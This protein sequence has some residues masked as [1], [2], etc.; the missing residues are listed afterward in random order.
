MVTIQ[1]KLLVGKRRIKWKKEVKDKKLATTTI[2]CGFC[3]GFL[4]A[5]EYEDYSDDGDY[6][7]RC[8]KC[9]YAWNEKHFKALYDKTPE[10][11]KKI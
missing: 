4:G 3:Y 5:L 1:L 7:R 10:R 9:N 6:F 2:Q 11:F 8:L